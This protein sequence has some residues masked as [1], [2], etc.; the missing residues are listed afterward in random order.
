MTALCEENVE[1]VSY[2]S[3]II[4]STAVYGAPPPFLEFDR[5]VGTMKKKYLKAI[6]MYSTE[7]SNI[8][9]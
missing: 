6:F 5:K 8:S 7:N 2:Y 4:L 3:L 1:N 9:L